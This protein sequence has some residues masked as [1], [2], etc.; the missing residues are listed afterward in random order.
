[1]F[2]FQSRG[3]KD[4]TFIASKPVQVSEKNPPNLILHLLKMGKR[5][6]TAFD[7]TEN[8]KHTERCAGS[9]LSILFKCGDNLAP[10]MTFRQFF[11]ESWN[12]LKGDNLGQHRGNSFIT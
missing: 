11:Q 9:M 2:R 4:A 8:G 12:V 6:L 7:L 10:D 3:M 1:M 5:V